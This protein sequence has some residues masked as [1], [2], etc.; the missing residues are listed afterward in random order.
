L[1]KT[2]ARNSKNFELPYKYSNSDNKKQ[3]VSKINYKQDVE[4]EYF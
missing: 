4:I 1:V 3:I 2:K